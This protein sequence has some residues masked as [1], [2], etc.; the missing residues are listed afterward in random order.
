MK[1]ASTIHRTIVRVIFFCLL[2]ALAAQVPQDVLLL[3]E[4]Q[5]NIFHLHRNCKSLGVIETE[6]SWPYKKTEYASLEKSRIAEEAIMRDMGYRAGANA[7]QFL[8]M[9]YSVRTIGRKIP[10]F[11]I[12]ISTDIRYW[13]CDPK[14]LGM[15]KRRE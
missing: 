7:M 13:K 15:L 2:S 1:F 9:K 3:E 6:R 4:E 5:V 14:T 8:G 12:D 11:R 10:E